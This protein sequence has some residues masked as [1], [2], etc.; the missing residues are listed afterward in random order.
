MKPRHASPPSGRGHPAPSPP[1]AAGCSARG[2]ATQRGFTLIEVLAAILLLAL[3]FSA[4]LG[5]AGA[6]S[7][8]TQNAADRSQAALWARSLLDGTFVSTPPQ[9]GHSSG[10]FDRKFGWQLDVTP[11]NE[12]GGGGIGGGVAEATQLY[13]V[14]LVVSWGP[15]AHPRA[16]RFRTL[17]LVQSPRGSAAGGSP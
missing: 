15:P 6:S 10:R 9:P 4:L 2:A 3:A 11:W 14:D 8:L 5:V 13:Q 1:A 12:G 17:R 7:A 16:A